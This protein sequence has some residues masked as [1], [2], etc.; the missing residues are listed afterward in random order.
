MRRI[1][2]SHNQTIFNFQFST[3]NYKKPHFYTKSGEK[4]YKDYEK[5]FDVLKHYQN[6]DYFLLLYFHPSFCMEKCQGLFKSLF[7]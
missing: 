5:N 2:T 4:Q 3:F 7:Y 1:S 6:V